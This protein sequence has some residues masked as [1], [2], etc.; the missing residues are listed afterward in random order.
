MRAFE[1]RPVDVGTKPIQ[2]NNDDSQY[3]TPEKKE[4]DPSCPA[5]LGE[6]L[7]RW[8]QT[9]KWHKVRAVTHRLTFHKHFAKDI[10][11]LAIDK[12]SR[13]HKLLAGQLADACEAAHRLC[14][15]IDR[16]IRKGCETEDELDDLES[17]KANAKAV[18]LELARIVDS[19]Q[20]NPG[21]FASS[22]NRRTQPASSSLSTREQ[23]IWAMVHV[24]GKSLGQAAIELKCSRQNI[25]K[26]LKNAEAKMKAISSRSVATGL[27]FPHDNRGQ[28]G[29]PVHSSPGE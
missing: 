24:Q 17:F 26:H 19:C 12:E 14:G 5:P 25:S 11:A 27:Q 9:N 10:R 16:L 28:A 3:R 15:K 8:G 18:I 23:R 21:V 7:R 13:G 6:R 20:P 29:I 4:M 22:S 2:Q 1:E